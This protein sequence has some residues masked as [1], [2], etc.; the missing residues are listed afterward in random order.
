MIILNLNVIS[1]LILSIILYLFGG[2]IKDKSHILSKF[3]IPTPVVGGLL[4]S[5]FIFFI[6]KFGLLEITMDTSLMPYFL[7]TFFVSIGFCINIS[8]IKNGSKLLF[9][10]WVLCAV[11]GFCQNIIAIVLSKILN[12]K[13]LLAFM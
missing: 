1:T 8:S 4:F 6:K 7:S 12:I 3:C 2:F 11:L 10:Y 13:P 5:V 9:I